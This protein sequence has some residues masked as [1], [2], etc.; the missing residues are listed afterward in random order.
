MCQKSET[1]TKCGK[2]LTTLHFSNDQL[3]NP[4]NGNSQEHKENQSPNNNNFHSVFTNIEK[5]TK[6]IATDE[7]E[8]S[9]AKAFY[10][11]TA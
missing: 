5:D 6:V 3:E 1:C 11:T 8:N 2:L 4:I 10:T 9:E 7:I